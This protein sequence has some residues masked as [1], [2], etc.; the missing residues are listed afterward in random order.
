MEKKELR[1]KA[2]A[3]F[4]VCALVLVFVYLVGESL[5]LTSTNVNSSVDQKS[6]ETINHIKDDGSVKTTD[7]FITKYCD[8]TYYGSVKTLDSD[9]KIKEERKITLILFNAMGRTYGKYY[10]TNTVSSYEGTF[11][12]KQNNK[13]YFKI[14][15]KTEE[16]TASDECDKIIK[17]EEDVPNNLTINYKLRKVLS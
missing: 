5:S 2:V 16:F 3:A 8:G 17:T 7:E 1:R 15:D 9:S 14:G 13:I 6:G 10:Y 11:T 4:V 12:T